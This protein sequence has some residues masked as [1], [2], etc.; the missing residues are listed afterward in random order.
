MAGCTVQPT[1]YQSKRYIYDMIMGA[2]QDITMDDWIVNK[3]SA[4][5]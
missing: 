1:Q 5:L 2:I 3:S 4:A